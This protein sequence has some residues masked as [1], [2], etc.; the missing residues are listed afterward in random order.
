MPELVSFDIAYEQLQS[1]WEDCTREGV[2]STD[3]GGVTKYGLSQSAY[4]TL[5]IKGLTAERA[6]QITEND[7]WSYLRWDVPSIDSEYQTLANK[8]FQF[9]FN[10]GVGTVIQ[11]ANMNLFIMG[12]L[13]TLP[14]IGAPLEVSKLAEVI[15]MSLTEMLA[16]A[17]LSRYIKDYNMLSRV[18]HSLLDRALC[19][20]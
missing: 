5:D 2:V 13:K 3:G 10:V 16:A 17:Q 8:L 20:E 6:K 14:K 4:P 15:A 7:Y 11:I 18:P 1:R 9:G 19:I 12:Q